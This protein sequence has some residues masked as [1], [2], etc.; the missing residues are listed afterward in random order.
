[1]MRP[2]RV[3]EGADDHDLDGI[4]AAADVACDIAFPWGREDVAGGLLVDEDFG[5][6]SVPVAQGDLVGIW[7]ALTNLGMSALY[8][9]DF[10]R[11]RDLFERSADAIAPLNAPHYDALTLLNR[12]LVAARQGRLTTA[13]AQLLEALKTF[14]ALEDRLR[15]CDCLESLALVAQAAKRYTRVVKYWGASTKLRELLR[16]PLPPVELKARKVAEREMR[17][18]MGMV[19]YEDSWEEGQRM[20]DDDFNGLIAFALNETTFADK[21][22]LPSYVA[23]PGLTRREIDV[24]QMVAQGL[25]DAQ[26]AERLIISPRT[27][28]AHLMSIYRKLEVNSRIAATL[29]AQKRGLV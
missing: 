9:D 6:A 4:L 15:I 5:D 29:E 23:T 26:V 20:A 18:M 27:V 12:G 24:L 25:T 21:H 22:G 3:L 2:E 14:A 17:D 19:L 8:E 7:S 1:M 10:E 16:S 11:A 28:N 13:T